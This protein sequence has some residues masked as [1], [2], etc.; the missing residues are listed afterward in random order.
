MAEVGGL[1][2]AMKAVGGCWIVTKRAS[3]LDEQ[4][5][6]WREVSNGRA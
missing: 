6:D 5:F 1:G 2:R 3:A 4:G